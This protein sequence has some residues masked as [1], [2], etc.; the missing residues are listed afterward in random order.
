M[1]N[2]IV[3]VESNSGHTVPRIELVKL[4]YPDTNRR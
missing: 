1:D 3:Q 2:E 4:L